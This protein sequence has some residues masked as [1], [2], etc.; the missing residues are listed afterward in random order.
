M[1]SRSS[2]SPSAASFVNGAYVEADDNYAGASTGYNA[3]IGGFQGN[4]T[5]QGAGA[6]AS[7]GW[8]GTLGALALA[9]A[10]DATATAAN[11]AGSAND[12]T[13]T[14]DLATGDAKASNV[15]NLDVD[16]TQRQLRLGG[17]RLRRSTCSVWASASCSQSNVLI[18]D[19]SFNQAYA[20]SGA[21]SRG[22]LA[23]AISPSRVG[24][25][26]PALGTRSAPAC[27]PV[28]VR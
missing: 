22:R 19:G 9:D 1:A 5:I 13:V 8:A 23:R 2:A 6:I 18:D 28:R 26:S 24:S 14:N 7:G 4:G 16:Q 25:Q 12:S 10:G 27:S 20:D 3:Q 11:L 21:T 17:R 15:V